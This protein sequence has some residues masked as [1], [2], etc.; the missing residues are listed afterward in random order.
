[1][2]SIFTIYPAPPTLLYAMGTPSFPFPSSV[3]LTLPHHRH[4]PCVCHY[5]LFL[6]HSKAQILCIKDGVH[7]LNHVYLNNGVLHLNYGDYHL[8]PSKPWRFS[9][10]P[11][12]LSS[13]P[14]T[15]HLNNG[16]YHLNHG[17]YHLKTME[18]IIYTMECII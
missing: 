16:V 3:T 4:H 13:K 7:Q 6:N 14:R 15:Y 12:R 11:L 2:D 17:L 10:K 9:S 1:M 18:I 5:T 8:N